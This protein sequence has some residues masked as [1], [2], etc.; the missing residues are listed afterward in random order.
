M[1]I[2]RLLVPAFSLVVAALATAQALAA[3]LWVDGR[4]YTLS[5]PYYTA[6]VGE[7]AVSFKEQLP[8]GARV[9]VQYG[10]GGWADDFVGGTTRTLD[11]ENV[12]YVEAEAAAPFVWTAKLSETLHERSHNWMY[13]KLQFVFIVTLPDGTQ[14]YEKGSNT[15]LGFYQAATPRPEAIGSD[16]DAPYQRL[17]VTAIGRF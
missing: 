4:F 15:P 10:L 3:D 2:T 7:F 6:T 12:S 5:P 14:Y 13:D 8:W 17:T 16:S 1:L 9:H 11:W